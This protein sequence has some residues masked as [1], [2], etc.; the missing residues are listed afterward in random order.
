MDGLRLLAR[1]NFEQQ[2]FNESCTALFHCHQIQAL[3][4]PIFANQRYC[5]LESQKLANFLAH[6]FDSRSAGSCEPT[7]RIIRIRQ[8]ADNRLGIP[9]SVFLEM[10]E[11]MHLDPYALYLISQDYDGLHHSISDDGVF[12]GFVGTALFCM[13]WTFD[14]EQRTT[15]AIVLIRW[16]NPFPAFDIVLEAYKEHISTPFFPI[17]A[18]VIHSI[19]AW[20]RYIAEALA[21]IRNIE[22]ATGHG[23]NTAIRKD[24]RFDLN[25]IACWLKTLSKVQGNLCNIV[26]HLNQASDMI[27]F[28]TEI[29]L[30][31]FTSHLDDHAR[32]KQAASFRTLHEALPAIRNIVGNGIPYLSYIQTRAQNLGHVV[33]KPAP[34]NPETN[35]LTTRV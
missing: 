5:C 8:E 32:G 18:V 23:P 2:Q 25:D 26:R 10:V 29:E 12:T 11:A 4:K 21:E 27:T 19:L 22:A 9:R 31:P 14:T 33:C 7:L 3:E 1:L 24:A 28:L 15:R 34:V 35:T 16:E 6:G 30:D 20:D 17:F 13:I